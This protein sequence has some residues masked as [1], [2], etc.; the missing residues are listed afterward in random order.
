MGV[1]I[2]QNSVDRDNNSFS[3]KGEWMPLSL[4]HGNGG[5]T[6]NYFI[7]TTVNLDSEDH[8]VPATTFVYTNPSRANQENIFSLCGLRSVFSVPLSIFSTLYVLEKSAFV[9]RPLSYTI[10]NSLASSLDG[11]YG[12]IPSFEEW[13]TVWATW[14]VITLQM[15]PKTMLHQKPIDLRHKCLFYIG[16]IPTFLDMLLHKSIGGGAT[17][18]TYFWNIFERGID[19]HVDDPDHCHNHSEVPVND[20]DWPTL[21]SVVAFRDAV[22]RR[23]AN[24]YYD[25]ATGKR[26]L[27]RNIARTLVMTHEHEGFHIETLLY[28]LIQRAGTGTLPPPGFTIPPWEDL[29][30]QWS[31]IPPPS[32]QTVIVGPATLV[33]GHHDSEADDQSPEY[34]DDVKGH[35]FGW[36]NE[37]PE[38]HV[39]VGAFKAEWRPISNHEFQQFWLRE[40]KRLGLQIPKSWV[41][42]DDVIKIRTLY[43]PVSMEIAAH[44]PIL[45]SYDDLVLFAASKGGRLPTEPELRLFLDLY[46]VGH[47]GGANIGF[48]NWHPVPATAGLDQFDGRGSNGG[49][50]E[51]TTTIFDNHQDLV[52]TQLFTGYSTD[53]FDTKHHVALGAS[54][55]TIPR[56]GRRTVRNFYQH[57]Y[58]YPWIGA[59]VVYDC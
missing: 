18:P 44:W 12:N 1:I 41:I 40:G 7:S 14:D 29:I 26:T 33:L 50:W 48:K 32:T 58:P 15:I 24:L 20:E 38:R 28:M 36:D 16:H 27:T 4:S 53:F 34:F 11:K 10:A 39:H 3:C 8:A 45:A 56:L 46:D 49:V 23:L 47:E 5:S 6:L 57:N 13:K 21:D 35:T 51:W 19:P 42:E 22:R 9:Y 25:L 37:S 2:D 54:Y 17:E 59:R 30:C 52:P 43:G 31:M 55:A